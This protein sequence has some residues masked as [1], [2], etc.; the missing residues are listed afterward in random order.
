[1]DERRLRR[2]LDGALGPEEAQEF[3]AALPEGARRETEALARIAEAA[4]AL[5]RATPPSDFA[6]RAMAR[7]RT[8]RP[9]RRSALAWLRTPALSPLAAVASALVVGA[10]S[11]GVASWRL[12]P[13]AGRPA[14]SSGAPMVDGRPMHPPRVL[15]RLTLLAPEAHEV[16]LAADFNGWNPAAARMRR[17]AGGIWTVEVP[18]E[19]GKRYQYMFVVDG[20]WR[21]N[22]QAP[23]VVA[24]GFGG[25]NAVLEL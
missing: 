15:A 23:A 2:W 11:F 22:P 12:G 19:P 13:T 24:D 7:V 21:T 3:L 6:A 17:G 8:R 10:V 1:M 14:A 18:L 4:R 9:P 25:K 5:P 16:S 20:A